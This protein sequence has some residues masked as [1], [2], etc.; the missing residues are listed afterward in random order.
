MTGKWDQ[1][2]LNRRDNTDQISNSRHSL[3]EHKAVF[4]LW[5]IGLIIHFFPQ[6]HL[7]AYIFIHILDMSAYIVVENIP[8][9]F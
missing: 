5:I 6:W 1:K 2:K 4:S 7:N 8:G 9:V 3:K